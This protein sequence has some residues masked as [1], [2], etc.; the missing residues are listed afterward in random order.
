MAEN[1]DK[2]ML[3]KVHEQVHT[4]LKQHADEG[5]AAMLDPQYGRI[6]FYGTFDAAFPEVVALVGRN[7]WV[8]LEDDDGDIR[9]TRNG[10]QIT[11]RAGLCDE[12]YG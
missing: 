10:M 2:P 1:T 8:R 12:V 9:L 4:L 11:L 6:D 3:H 5:D 7:D